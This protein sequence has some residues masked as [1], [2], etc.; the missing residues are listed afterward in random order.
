MAFN[1]LNKE[2]DSLNCSTLVVFSKAS[3]Q[4]DKPAKVTHSELNKKFSKII[5]EKTISGK[6]SET[7]VFREI[8]YKGF[9]NVIVVGLGTENTL[10]HDC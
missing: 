7:I 10:H 6:L 9:R 4:K 3:S 8:G 5:T 1:L 2:I